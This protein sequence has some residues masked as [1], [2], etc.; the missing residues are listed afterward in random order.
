MNDL[1]ASVAAEAKMRAVFDA[2][3]LDAYAKDQSGLASKR[4]LAV[5]EPQNAEDVVRLVNA[6]R[7]AQLHLVPVSSDGPRY[8][9]DT[10]C[11]ERS[12]I[13][14]MRRLGKVIRCD[15]RNRVSVFEAGVNFADLNQAAR[16]AGLRPM[17]PLAP[18]PGKSV[19][20]AYLER[21]P[22]IFPIY[23]WD[24]SDPL[25]C[26]EV[27]FGTGELF[28]T[29][30]AAGPGSL[31]EQWRAGDAQKSPM[32][33]G[34]SDLMR[35]VQGAQGT[36]GIVTWCSA[37]CERLPT[38][39]TLHVIASDRL[40]PLIRVSY[41]MLRRKHPE[42]LFLVDGR[43]LVALL[44]RDRASYLKGIASAP[45]WCLVYSLA[46]P[47]EYG[48]EKLRYMRREVDELC[49]GHQVGELAPLPVGSTTELLRNLTRPE[50]VRD[51]PYFKQAGLP[52]V[53]ELFFQ[54]TLDRA[55]VFLTQAQQS[56]REAGINV[57]NMLTYV[58]PQLG[59]RVCHVEIDLAHDTRETAA[60]TEFMDQLAVTLKSLG[61]FFSR[62]YGRLS[63]LA[64]QGSSTARLVPKVKRIFDPDGI[65]SP[66]NLNPPGSSTTT[67]KGGG[68]ALQ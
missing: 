49:A 39:E 20:A 42:I 22:T 45:R 63:E 7:K 67:S 62:P 52:H 46:S 16:N 14:N 34:Q 64:F 23:Q 29:G 9:P 50:L 65:L 30:S 12:V 40:E 19:L 37:K 11:D 26:I 44:A 6:A 8:R 56:M 41:E 2:A 58:Q 68:H 10:R 21:E 1:I 31:E 66:L 5:F 55:E 4:P 24:I 38:D 13:V 18:R 25:L 17:L 48:E 32:G 3:L 15:R 54:T 27:V 28:R 36:I 60:C 61:A 57:D 33:P 53:R 43:A 59:G 51:L 35:L 47:A